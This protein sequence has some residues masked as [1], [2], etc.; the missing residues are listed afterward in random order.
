ML[1]KASTIITRAIREPRAVLWTP[2]RIH[3]KD[4]HPQFYPEAQVFHNGKV[5]MT[6]GG[7]QDSY[8][9][10]LWSGNHPFFQG[11]NNAVVVDEGQVIRFKKRFAG[12]EK[13]STT[14]TAPNSVTK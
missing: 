14:Q 12:L 5:V 1:I 9:V 13:L 11:A 4:I 8:V 2:V 7:S 6:L 10:D 3:A